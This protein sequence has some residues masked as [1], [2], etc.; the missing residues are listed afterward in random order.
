[1]KL[2]SLGIRLT[3]N[4]IDDE[5]F[6]RIGIAVKLGMFI[7]YTNFYKN[8]ET[9]DNICILYL[10]LAVQPVKNRALWQFIG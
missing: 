8:L 9:S 5:I 3:R 2:A 10:V 4:I 1:M 6:A 7:P